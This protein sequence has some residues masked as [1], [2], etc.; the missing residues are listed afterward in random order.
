MFMWIR[1]QV[2][3]SV[4]CEK[5]KENIKLVVYLE[6]GLWP[7]SPLWDIWYAFLP[8]LLHKFFCQFFYLGM[9]I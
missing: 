9:Y 5:I 1:V 4:N 3:V 2:A 7:I 6:K 8:Y